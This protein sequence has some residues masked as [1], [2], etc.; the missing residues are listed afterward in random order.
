MISAG[1]AVEGE[2]V[3]LKSYPEFARRGLSLF[4]SLSG[5]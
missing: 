4:T 3:A 2:I 5:E 1:R